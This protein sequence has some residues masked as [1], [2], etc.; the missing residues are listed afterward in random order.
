MIAKHAQ[1]M[2][3]DDRIVQ[4]ERKRLAFIRNRKQKIKDQRTYYLHLVKE[5][6]SKY[7]EQRERRRLLEAVSVQN[8]EQEELSKAWAIAK[9][10]IFR[11]FQS[12]AQIVVDLLD[13]A[14]NSLFLR[15]KIDGLQ[16]LATELANL[17]ILSKEC[18]LW[19][20][21]HQVRKVQKIIQTTILHVP[22]RVQCEM[23]V[24][25]E[26]LQEVL[27]TLQSL[28][29]GKG[30]IFC[31]EHVKLQGGRRQSLL[32]LMKQSFESKRTKSAR[33]IQTEYRGYWARKLNPIRIGNNAP[34]TTVQR[35]FRGFNVRRHNLVKKYGSGENS[36]V[37]C[38]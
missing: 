8:T 36:N 15:G 14:S 10:G 35:A 21:I 20:S 25:S 7:T 34:A 29:I 3:L 1:E 23:I 6:E 22:E 19:G 18:N 30:V 12:T 16:S 13:G 28:E 24:V 5:C 37:V 17:V 33:R 9:A 32:R 4:I 2:N 38:L 11:A 31:V 26:N 27:T